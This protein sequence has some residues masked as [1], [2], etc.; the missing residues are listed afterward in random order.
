ML[1]AESIEQV[2]D[3]LCLGPP[4]FIY[5]NDITCPKLTCSDL[6]A[7]M[8]EKAK[9]S[10]P[11]IHYVVVDGL[12]CFTA[13][14]LFD[15]IIN[16]FALWEPIW[17]EGCSNWSVEG[18]G[19]FNENLDGF[20]NG[21]KAV[22][23]HLL[24]ENGNENV[25]LIL[26]VEKPERLRERLPDM[27]VPLT[28][29]SEITKS[30]ISV[31]FISETRWEDIRPP[32]A[33]ALDPLYVDVPIPSKE[34]LVQY[35]GSTFLSFKRDHGA[36]QP[37]L[38]P[39]YIQFI[40][41]L[42]EV[43][44]LYVKNPYELQ[45]IAAARWPGYVKPVLDSHQRDVKIAAQNGSPA[46]EPAL[47]PEHVRIRLS[48]AFKSSLT[49]AMEQLYPRLTNAADWAQANAP[50]DGL[51]DKL[52][53]TAGQL[54][55]S[56]HGEA[57]P[58]TIHDRGRQND[59][60]LEFL[61]R[62][63][64]FILVASYLASMN[65]TK[66]DLR[67]FGRGVDEKKR[68]RRANTMK[69][70]TKPLTGPVKIPQHYVG[71]SSFP[72]DRMI[73]VL[74]A[75]LEDNDANTK[76][77]ASE[78]GI[79]GEYTDMEITRVG[80][81]SS[82]IE[83]TTLGLLHRNTV[84]EKLDGA[85][86]FKCAISYEAALQLAQQLDVKLHDLL[87]DPIV[88]VK[89]FKMRPP[90]PSIPEKEFL[91]SSLK[92]SQ[93]LDGRLPLEMRTPELTFSAELGTVESNVDAKMV[94]PPP[95]RPFE[96]LITIH[97]EISPMASSEYE[98]GRPS[99]EE[100]TITRMLDKV[101]RRSD[102]MDKESLCIQAGQRVWHLRLTIHCLSDAGNLLDCACLAGIV[103]LKHFR[104]PEVEVVGDEVTVHPPTSRAPL[105]LSLHHTPY[106]FTFAFFH[107]VSIPPVLDPNQLEQRL[108][109]GLMSIALN[110]QRELCVV[111][112]SG[113]VPL[114]PEDVLKIVNIAVDR[115]KELDSL[116][117]ARLRED[118]ATRK[119]EVE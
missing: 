17:N 91:F 90:S 105:P 65:P 99:E 26:V 8:S 39:M 85:P 13:R 32:L 6:V 22:F 12:A 67:M 47:P 46:P 49:G 27:I 87:W 77:N 73:A 14:I 15:T 1:N 98:L 52:L 118:W 35:L 4:P 5:L 109:G 54:S 23:S 114:E 107:D 57:E 106:C 45:Y 112:K 41:V 102:T 66:T 29:L 20:L 108:N 100:V 48:N 110:A 80:V 37:F 55:P 50:E 24:H 63:S 44:Y 69:A 38:H 9:D 2:V 74:G 28:R 104:R 11:R 40:S 43:C 3:L 36:Y 95:E 89:L 96:G 82:I 78:F 81:S 92:Q 79:A 93:R 70:S 113:G 83:L 116:V 16:G 42:L 31:I 84:P 68:K 94:K 10:K 7:S 119:I 21:I 62:M 51:L 30:D 75:L 103:A 111:Q 88:S 72:L 59:L 18:S 64:K 101:I 117:E 53:Q 97:S 25:R 60:G 86:L 56:R 34:D 115:A 19:R 76:L 58:V 61:P 71:P 33:A